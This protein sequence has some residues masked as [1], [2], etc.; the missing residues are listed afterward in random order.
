MTIYA[1][2][3]RWSR[4]GTL[5][6]HLISDTSLDELH[7]VAER[8]GIHP[9]SFDLDHYD[10]P[11]PALPD[12]LAAGATQVGNGELTR[13]LIASGLRVPAARRPRARM[14]RTEKAVRDLGLSFVPTDLIWGERGHVEPL[15]EAAVAP[16]GAFRIA[17]DPGGAPRVQAHDE[18]GRTGAGAFLVEA[19]ALAQAVGEERFIGQVLSLPA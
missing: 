14:E 19:D 11:Q 2:T 10:W 1:D 13:I 6:G 3:P 5:W 7:G 16:T 9:R 15:P 12:L 4:H 8:A 18:A 17:V